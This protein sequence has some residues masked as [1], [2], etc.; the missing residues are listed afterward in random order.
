MD[1]QN[2]VVE[3][4]DGIT[5]V[6]VTRPSARNALS[7]RTMTELCELLDGLATPLIL[8]GAPGPAFIAGADISEMAGMT[9]SEGERFGRLGQSVTTALESMPA[10][11]IACVDGYALGGGCEIAL[12]CDFVYATEK[13]VFGQPEVSLGLIPGFGGCVRLQQQVGPARAREL[14]YSGRTVD[15]DEAHRIGLVNRLF[16]DRDAMLAGAR[17]MLTAIGL[18]SSSAVSLCKAAINAA[19]GAD[20]Q[21]GLATELAAFSQAF[22]TPDMREGTAAF[23]DKRKPSFDRD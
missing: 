7:A 22:M 6:T 15:A 13:A 18:N 20:V 10:P 19:R 4:R 8:T 12:A 3:L 2:L 23:L 21:T 1:Y 9:P 16:V 5:T 14:I 17:H 11:V